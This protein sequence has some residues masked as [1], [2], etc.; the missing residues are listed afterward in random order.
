MISHQLLK[1]REL[2]R[3]AVLCLPV[4]LAGSALGQTS[5]TLS[6]AS[7]VQGSRTSLSLS[8]A[9]TSGSR[10]AALQWVLMFPPTDVTAISAVVG[11]SGKQAGK[12][13][14]CQPGA[15]SYVCL[16]SGLNNTVL[17]DGVIAVVNVT[18]SS[19]ASIVPIGVINAMGSTSDGLA[20]TVSGLAGTVTRI[21]IAGLSCTPASLASSGT[22][23]CTVTLSAPAQSP[24]YVS[25][26]ST[27]TQLTTPA[28]IAIPAGTTSASFTA[29]SGTI[30]T[31]FTATVTAS[32]N[33]SSQATAISLLAP[34]QL[35]SLSCAAT[36]AGSGWSTGCT[37]TLSKPAPASGAVVSLASSLGTLKVPP[38]VAVAGGQTS[39]SF[40]ATVGTIGS[41]Q[42]AAITATL[43][44]TSQMVKIALV[45]VALSGISCS[46]SSLKPGEGTNC[47]VTLSI[48][49]G[50]AGAVVTLTSSAPVLKLP[51]AA[52]VAAGSAA[53]SFT[54]MAGTFTSNQ[55]V[56]VT[57]QL[58]GT[59]AAT[60][61]ALLLAS[62]AKSAGPV[63][64]TRPI[65]VDC[66]AGTIQAGGWSDC[67]LRLTPS[68]ASSEVGFAVFSTSA[69][70]KV[71]AFVTARPGQTRIR[72][73]AYAER[74]ASYQTA[75]IAV[76]S[77]EEAV[78]NIVA[79]MPG[80]VRSPEKRPVRTAVVNAATRM[81]QFACSPGSLASIEGRGLS[82]QYLKINGESVPVLSVAPERLDL[83]CPQS[84]PGTLLQIS[85]ENDAGAVLTVS[86]TMNA[87]APGLF[88]LDGSGTGEGAVTLAGTSRIATTRD[89]RD[90]G[91]PVV[92][93]DSI[94]LL[95][96]GIDPESG[97][98]LLKIGDFFVPTS[99]IKAIPGKPGIYELTATVP[100]GAPE[101]DAA[102]VTLI[103]PQFASNTVTI[104]IESAK[105]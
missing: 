44:A 96:T 76:G 50:T 86:T 95:A 8:L 38:S 14:A 83:L 52:T 81:S 101:S 59:V 41:A 9:S 46:P 20:M 45:P 48:A 3:T 100:L 43:N 49:A 85:V 24:T 19:T 30:S 29:T 103:L 65:H 31:D 10:P 36:T 89:Y 60:S 47:T 15:G 72:F 102:P 23:K 66:P 92:P 105:Y 71:P 77:G 80:R 84:A 18:T 42:T 70:V 97:P 16:L 68:D 39:A 58:N 2:F 99:G 88:S 35:S 51:T 82:G 4:L 87:A 13:V 53:V 27:S 1:N 56:Q 78:K 75:E 21:R 104:A 12:T 33:G 93:G 91:Q 6:S 61:V 54:A 40:N 5:L 64:G 67:E 25:L 32:L 79:V 74:E 63:T 11:I 22:A 34:S 69:D 90:L 73:R 57:A 98:F 17:P 26:S 62:T 55:S 28:W 7:L 37:V 94:A